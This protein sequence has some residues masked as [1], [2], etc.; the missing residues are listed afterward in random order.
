MCISGSL[1]RMHNTGPIGEGRS[2]LVVRGGR[3]G[4]ELFRVPS[5]LLVVASGP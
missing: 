4:V 3:V 2:P 5:A 1:L